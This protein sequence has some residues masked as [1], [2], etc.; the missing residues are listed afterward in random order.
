MS[1]KRK[2][3]AHE[4]LQPLWSSRQGLSKLRVKRVQ[5]GGS[6]STESTRTYPEGKTPGL[7]FMAHTPPKFKPP[8]PVLTQGA[9]FNCESGATLP[10][11]YPR[12]RAN[13]HN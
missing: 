9:G 13:L 11:I 10:H 5:R 1:Q 8:P 3:N 2:R 7:S 12:V 6:V 4:T